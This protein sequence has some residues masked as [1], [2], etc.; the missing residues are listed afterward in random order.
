MNDYKI[1]VKYTNDDMTTW[2]LQADNAAELLVNIH[3]EA[4]LHQLDIMKIIITPALQRLICLQ[5]FSE[6][7]WMTKTEKVEKLIAYMKMC[8]IETGKTPKGCQVEIDIKK[9]DNSPAS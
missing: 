4:K 7:D 2:K 6:V 3:S 1:S 8:G 9:I 5:N